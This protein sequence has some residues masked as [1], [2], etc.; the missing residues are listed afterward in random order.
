MTTVWAR[1]TPQEYVV[2]FVTVS[3]TT[4]AEIILWLTAWHPMYR[5]HL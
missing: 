4:L 5:A 1:S 3:D 2:L